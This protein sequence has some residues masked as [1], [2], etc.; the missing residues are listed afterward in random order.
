MTP[1]GTTRSPRARHDG[2]VRPEVAVDHQIGHKRVEGLADLQRRQPDLVSWDSVAGH[3]VH[4]DVHGGAVA[5]GRVLR[6]GLGLR[7]SGLLGLNDHLLRSDLHLD[8]L[9][10]EWKNLDGASGHAGRL[11][12]SR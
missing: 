2:E 6:E 7:R 1:N 12:G 8:V 9:G 11:G 10:G 5:I 3:P 4:C